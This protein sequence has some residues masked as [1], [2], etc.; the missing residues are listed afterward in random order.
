MDKCKEIV[1]PMISSTYVDQDESGV[2]I[3]ISRYRGMASSWL[4][5]TSSRPG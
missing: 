5:L 3:D 2:L 4:Y 1:T